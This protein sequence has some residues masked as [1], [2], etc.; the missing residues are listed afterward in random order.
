LREEGARLGVFSG[1]RSFAATK[2]LERANLG[3]YFDF[4]VTADDSEDRVTRF[5]IAKKRA[6]EHLVRNQLLGRVIIVDDS[7]KTIV[8]GKKAGIVTVAVATGETSEAVLAKVEP[9]YL[10]KDLTNIQ[11]FVDIVKQKSGQLEV[12]G[13]EQRVPTTQKE[14]KVVNITEAS[15]RYNPFKDKDGVVIISEPYGRFTVVTHNVQTPDNKIIPNVWT[16]C[17]RDGAL[18]VPVKLKKDGI[19][20][21][22]QDEFKV[23]TGEMMITVPQGRPKEGETNPETASREF[24]EESG[25]VPLKIIYLGKANPLPGQ[26]MF[27]NHMYM[28]IL[29]ENPTA[30]NAQR[31]TV[32]RIGKLTFHPEKEILAMINGDEIRDMGTQTAILRALIR[33]KAG[34][35]EVLRSAFSLANTTTQQST[36]KPTVRSRARST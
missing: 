32:E 26:L 35:G 23:P 15:Y 21:G 11:R 36:E 10:F 2:I 31:D 12:K 20:I 25:M 16:V 3:Q 33:L 9:D 6:R 28:A 7:T 17:L 5:E 27:N 4:V 29:P 22:I 8:A 14:I 18:V 24:Q 34:D 19:Y 1:N 13:H 30:S